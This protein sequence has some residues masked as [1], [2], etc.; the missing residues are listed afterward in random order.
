MKRGDIIARDITL[1]IGTSVLHN[2]SSMEVAKSYMEEDF[3]SKFGFLPTYE[4]K[5]DELNPTAQAVVLTQ[6][7]VQHEEAQVNWVIDGAC[8]IRHKDGTYRIFE[9]VDEPEWKV[10]QES[11][12][13]YQSSVENLSDDDL[14]KAIDSL[15][16][17]RSFVTTKPRKT[18]TRTSA[19]DKSDPLAV[20]LAS[21][22]TDKKLELMKKMGM[23]D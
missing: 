13:S 10:I 9:V 23:V 5:Q 14:R 11:V 18:S 19:V 7:V 4:L 17:Q 2:C 12:P 1:E 6:A 21:M 8:A 16:E 22:P 15:R 20:A 3:V